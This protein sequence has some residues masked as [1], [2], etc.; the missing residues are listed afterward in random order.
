MK[1]PKFKIGQHVKWH[2]YGS[3]SG[4][5]KGFRYSGNGIFHYSVLEDGRQFVTEIKE[6]DI[7]RSIDQI[8]PK[9]KIG[10]IVEYANRYFVI[11]K[12][13]NPIVDWYRC[14]LV[15]RYD[16]MASDCNLVTDILENN[17]KKM[18]IR[19]SQISY[20]C[21]DKVA[22][23]ELEKV[24]IGY[25]ME[26]DPKLMKWVIREVCNGQ[27]TGVYSSYW[28][29]FEKNFI[30]ADTFGLY[31]ESGQSLKDILCLIQLSKNK[32]EN[33]D[34][35]SVDDKPC[36]KCEYMELNRPD[37]DIC[38][39]CRASLGD[40][41]HKN[42]K[43]IGFTVHKDPKAEEGLPY[44]LGTME[45]KFTPEGA[46]S[47]KEFMNK[48]YGIH[49]E[50]KTMKDKDLIRCNGNYKSEIKEVIFHYPAT[51]INW[52]DGTKTVVKCE[53]GVE[54]DKKVGFLLCLCKKFFDNHA[55]GNI[56]HMIDE[57]ETKD[58]PVKAKFEVGDSVSTKHSMYIYT[59]RRSYYDEKEKT[60]KYGCKVGNFFRTFPENRLYI[61]RD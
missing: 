49:K 50:D 8:D 11:T 1:E 43:R 32:I 55:Y 23:V 26:Y 37:N 42:F 33:M 15:Y 16:L 21:G 5:I 46:E 58:I 28:R 30:P 19:P 35:F 22:F 44:T 56:I 2:G 41:Y 38:K 20:H 45:L 17:I 51:I 18:V 3:K 53:E 4:I 12:V 60:W 6:L 48:I 61:V 29:E 25:L 39:D 52:K 47:I 57:L 10:D 13:Y 24:R 40:T 7:Y 9:F 27:R 54:L 36:R 59:I 14:R 34:A 31:D